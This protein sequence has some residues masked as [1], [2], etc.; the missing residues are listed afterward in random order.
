MSK[1]SREDIRS[2]LR[3]GDEKKDGVVTR[4]A[5]RFAA[6]GR[7]ESG[8]PPDHRAFIR[9]DHTMCCPYHEEYGFHVTRTWFG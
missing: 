4:V 3:Q 9:A 5:K 1:Q 2:R 7:E 6:L 8:W